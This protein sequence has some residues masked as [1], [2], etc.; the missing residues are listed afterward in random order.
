MVATVREAVARAEVTK[1]PLC[2]VSIDFSAALDQISHSYLLAMLH[3]HGFTDWFLQRIMGM[4]NKAALE[5][6]INGFRSSMIPIHSSI[7]Q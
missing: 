1:N 2:I 5:V 7:R 6:Q 4:N 3:A